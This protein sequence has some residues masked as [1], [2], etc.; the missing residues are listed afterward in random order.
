MEQ[1]S[2]RKRKFWWSENTRDAVAKNR[3]ALRG[4]ASASKL[5]SSAVKIVNVWNARILKE[6]RRGGPFNLGKIVIPT[7]LPS[8]LMLP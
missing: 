6:E 7:P 1:C 5:T 3:G 2:T 4:I 8:R